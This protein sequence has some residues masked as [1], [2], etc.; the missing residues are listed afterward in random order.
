MVKENNKSLWL[1]GEVKRYMRPDGK[2]NEIRKMIKSGFNMDMGIR[3]TADTLT[4][5]NIYKFIQDWHYV[6]RNEPNTY[7]FTNE[8][9][10][11]KKIRIHE[12]ILRPVQEEHVEEAAY[13]L[14]STSRNQD[15]GMHILINQL[16]GFIEEKLQVKIKLGVRWTTPDLGLLARLFH[17]LISSG[18]AFIWISFLI[19][20]LIHWLSESGALMCS[21]NSLRSSS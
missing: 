15:G 10:T 13:I 19:A 9:D 20:M 21:A 2:I 4:D 17:F 12:L 6:A 8:E 11:T 16:E 5:K 7:L 18:K 1:E 3:F 14:G